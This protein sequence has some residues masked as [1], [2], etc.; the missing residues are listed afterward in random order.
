MTTTPRLLVLTGLLTA[1]F[2]PSDDGVP[3]L[4]SRGDDAST[5]AAPADTGDPETTDESDDGSPQDAGSSD[6]GDAT[7]ATDGDD[8]PDEL[9]CDPGATR[10]N[11]CGAC[12]R[13]LQVCAEAGTWQD[14]G[15][16]SDEGVCSP[17]S[18]ENGGACGQLCGVQQRACDDACAWGEWI[19]VGEG[20]CIAGTAEN[21]AQPC[22]ACGEAQQRS[23][24]C[25]D[26][27]GWGEW[28]E[29]SACIDL[30]MCSPG[31]VQEEEQA[32][33]N[34]GTQTRS[35]S[36]AND[37]C[38]W[39]EWGP[40]GGC[41]EEGPCAAGQLDMGVQDCGACD[42]EQQRDRICDSQCQWG[43]WGP[44]GQCFECTAPDEPVCNGNKGS[45]E[46]NAASCGG[47]VCCDIGEGF[48]TGDFCGFD[49]FSCYYGFLG[50]D[51][52]EDCTW[53]NYCCGYDG[54]IHS[55]W[56]VGWGETC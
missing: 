55:G 17:R 27:C 35:R 15:G 19:C 30:G 29:W 25:S 48:T 24:V 51:S 10:E 8:V 31:E 14:A 56:C 39:G 28:S 7:A 20:E 49:A 32:C 1:C 6:D 54:S 12:G 38:S 2:Q 41:G 11:D 9:D 50:C 23:R 5:S 43:E 42:G 4:E 34:C 47:A 33:G 18:V 16:C 52:D 37:G 3:A 46:C 22:G 45:C 13:Q 40:W 36:C 53:G 26:D 44:W 21:D